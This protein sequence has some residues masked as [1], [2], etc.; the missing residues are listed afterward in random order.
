MRQFTKI[1]TKDP[2]SPL[3]TDPIGMNCNSAKQTEEFQLYDLIHIGVK[4]GKYLYFGNSYT[5]SK[6]DLD[7]NDFRIKVHWKQKVNLKQNWVN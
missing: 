2:I 7:E 6:S 1:G 4:A 3:G 5:I